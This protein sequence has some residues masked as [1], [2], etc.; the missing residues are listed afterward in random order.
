[1][2]EI[3]HNRI[4]NPT[5]AQHATRKVVEAGEALTGHNHLG[6]CFRYLAEAILC[7]A[8]GTIEPPVQDLEPEGYIV[9]SYVNGDGVVHL[10]KYAKALW[11]AVE[12]SRILQDHTRELAEFAHQAH[13]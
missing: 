10:C 8:D 4:S 7:A 9:D 2:S 11:R 6:H 12:L 13:T 3:G 1:V 5:H